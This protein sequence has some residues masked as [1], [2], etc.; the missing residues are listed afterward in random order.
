MDAL[1]AFRGN[2]LGN[3]TANRAQR[4]E[5]FKALTE[6]YRTKMEA[7]GGRGALF[8]A[9]LAAAQQQQGAPKSALSNATAS[10]SGTNKAQDTSG[11]SGVTKREPNKELG[12]DAYLQLLVTQ[13]SNQDPLS[14][15]DNTAMVAQLAQFSA[16]EQMNNLNESFETL[17]GNVDQLNFLSAEGM[18]GRYVEGLDADKKVI[19]GTVKGVALNG[20]IVVLDVDGKALP[21]SGVLVIGKEPPASSGS[22]SESKNSPVAGGAS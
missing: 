17:S 19:K 6:N 2:Q 22:N 14:P 3:L 18:L 12:K 8:K 20:S 5:A 16:L 21:M 4:T 15:M 13:L 1:T 9:I 7:A 10:S 11:D